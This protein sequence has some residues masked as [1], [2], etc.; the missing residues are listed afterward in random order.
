MPIR[1][2]VIDRTV[3][4]LTNTGTAGSNPLGGKH[5]YPHIPV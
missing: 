2:D 5:L 1:I 4:D 3:T